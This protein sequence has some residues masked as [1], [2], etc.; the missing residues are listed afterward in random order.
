MRLKVFDHS[1]IDGYNLP[2]YEFEGQGL[3]GELGHGKD[4]FIETNISCRE[5][6]YW[7][8]SYINEMQNFYYISFTKG[9]LISPHR[10]PEEVE[11]LLEQNKHLNDYFYCDDEGFLLSRKLISPQI[12]SMLALVLRNYPKEDL[13]KIS[14]RILQDVLKNT[15]SIS[16]RDYL[17]TAFYSSI[18]FNPEYTRILLSE[19]YLGIPNGPG[20][21]LFYSFM[22]HATLSTF[23]GYERAK[24]WWKKEEVKELVD[25]ILRR[26]YSSPN[27]Y[28]AKFVRFLMEE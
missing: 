1:K 5:N 13:E 4:G 16:G 18:L 14:I 23:N 15:N 26:H 12:F 22:E 20:R 3:Y 28:T 27:N 8:I 21:L 24:G 6:L 11:N 2:I 19:N 9:I 25:K 10:S 17:F 7:K